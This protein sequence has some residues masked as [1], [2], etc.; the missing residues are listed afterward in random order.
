MESRLGNTCSGGLHNITF[1]KLKTTERNT[2]ENVI[3][4]ILP[5]VHID[6][7][8]YIYTF[9]LQQRPHCLEQELIENNRLS[10]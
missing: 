1:L 6:V 8:E 5:N 2:F 3:Y 7:G 10:K 9:V 4:Y